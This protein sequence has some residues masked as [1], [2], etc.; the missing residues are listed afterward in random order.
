M[1]AIKR[2]AL[3]ISAAI[4]PEYL[5]YVYGDHVVCKVKLLSERICDEVHL[6]FEVKALG[7]SQGRELYRER[8][9]L[10]YVGHAETVFEFDVP[11]GIS[12]ARALSL[13]ARALGCGEAARDSILVPL[14]D[15]VR[16][17]IDATIVWHHHQPPNYL[18]S[19]KY[20]AEYPFKWVWYDLFRPHVTGGPYYVHAMVYKA[21]PQV[22][23]V[24]HLSP[25]LVRQWRSAIEKGYELEGGGRVPA[26]DPRVELTKRTLDLYKELA[27]LNLEIVT[28]G[29]VHTILGY[30]LKHFDMEDIIREN[31]EVGIRITKET[32]GGTPKGAWTPEMAWHPKLVNLYADLGI[33]Y[34][35]LCGKS[36]FPGAFGDKGDIYE[37]Y[38]VPHQ[39]AAITVLF[40][41]AEVSDLIGFN[42]N[43][44][45]PLEAMKGARNTVLL[46]LSRKGLLTVA[47]DGENWMIFSKYPKNTY[48]YLYALYDYLD[49]MQRKG[50]IRTVTA[51]E[52]LRERPASRTLFYIPTTSWLGSFRKWDSELPDQK[53]MWREIATAYEIVRVYE[54]IMG[55][56]APEAAS[57]RWA[58]SH[59]LDSDYWWAEFWS[60]E[61]IRSWLGELMAFARSLVVRPA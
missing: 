43:F 45:N 49:R 46:M 37:P 2:S 28:S 16:K 60:P 14:V 15:S 55:R 25:S 17:L 42:N 35:V 56:G 9:I 51:S 31:L 38:R 30:L 33:E 1:R 23:T 57:M 21:F 5:A 7:G 4:M 50:F 27:S 34:T 36:H 18:P 53:H 6:D 26:E 47:L 29:Y 58:L 44:V 3:L 19:G 24:V 59:A 10:K 22:K 12:S 32:F 39:Q 41:D 13:E 48:H 52:A 8:R 54:N 40:R 61:V 20:F 11:S